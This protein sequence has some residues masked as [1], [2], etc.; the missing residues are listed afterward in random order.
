MIYPGEKYGVREVFPGKF[1]T[2]EP[3]KKPFLFASSVVL[4]S[5]LLKIPKLQEKEK[6]MKPLSFKAFLMVDDTGLELPQRSFWQM[7]M[8]CS[9]CYLVRKTKGFGVERCC[10]VVA[11]I[12]AVRLKIRLK[13]IP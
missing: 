4:L 10:L 5:Y 2:I 8:S 11:C 1:N 9:Q 3:S 6:A 12:E 13:T 7:L